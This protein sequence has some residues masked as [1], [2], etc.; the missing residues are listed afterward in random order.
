[1][2]TSIGVGAALNAVS[3]LQNQISLQQFSQTAARRD[4]LVKQ[5]DALRSKL[6][7]DQLTLAGLEGQQARL[8][9]IQT[10]NA[11]TTTNVSTTPTPAG[12]KAIDQALADLSGRIKTLQDQIKATTDQITAL[13]QLAGSAPTTPDLKTVE[14]PAAPAAPAKMLTDAVK[15]LLSNTASGFDSPKLQASIVLDNFL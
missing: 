9:A 14:A 10:A 4:E 7:S 1:V 11:A 3:G 6:Y 5:A 15:K 8:Q 12:T 2:Q 13:D